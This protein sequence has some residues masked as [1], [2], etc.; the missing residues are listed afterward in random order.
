MI[1]HKQGASDAA[2]LRARNVGGDGKEWWTKHTL[3][4][5]SARPP[6]Q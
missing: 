5:M 2:E 1:K 3:S 4:R 6:Q